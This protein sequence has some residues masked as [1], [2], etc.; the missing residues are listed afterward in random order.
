M[1][2]TPIS[3]V[4]V[5][6][7]LVVYFFGDVG[8]GIDPDASPVYRAVTT[9]MSS[10]VFTSLNNAPS[11]NGYTQLS[12]F[13]NPDAGQAMGSVILTYV[14]KDSNQIVSWEDDL[15]KFKSGGIVG[16]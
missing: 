7:N 16:D 13:S 8:D 15:S 3:L 14:Q 11:P 2:N 4:F 5:G 9:D 12:A 10:F 1:K 6:N